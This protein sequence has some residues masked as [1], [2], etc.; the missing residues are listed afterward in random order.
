M[1]RRALFLVRIEEWKR[2]LLNQG[3]P[4]STVG[5]Y[6]KVAR[7][8]WEHYGKEHEWPQDPRKITGLEVRNYMEFLIRWSTGTQS[9][10]TIVLLL[11]LRWSG[12]KNL[13]RF[14]VRIH[15]QRGNVDWLEKEQVAAVL[16]TAP[17]VRTLGME[18][19]YVYTGLRMGEV[20][21]LRLE[22][23]TETTLTI[24]RGKGGKGRS[25]PVTAQFWEAIAPYMEWRRQYEGT[26]FMIHLD[27]TDGTPLPYTSN[28]M[29]KAIRTHS[30]MLGFHFTAHT[31]RRSFGR[32]LYFAGMPLP[33]ISYLYGHSSLEMT[34]RYIGIRDSDARTSLDKF[35]SRY[36]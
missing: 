1:P 34:L 6:E 26:P 27:R 32:H 4:L 7:Y 21:Q 33:E 9:L 30:D 3:Y 28:G 16:S 19:L 25:V 31:F 22:D 14:K 20:I 8:A 23:V 5:M 35:Q 29:A 12:N 15:V 2:D 17:N 36:I 11:F 18:C 13:E 10:R 24:R